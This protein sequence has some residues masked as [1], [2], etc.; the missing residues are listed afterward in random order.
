LKNGEHLCTYFSHS[1]NF[2]KSLHSH[3]ENVILAHIFLLRRIK[4]KTIVLP[5][6]NKR[7]FEKIFYTFVCI[8]ILKILKKKKKTFVHILKICKKY[9]ETK[10]CLKKHFLHICIHLVFIFSF[11]KKILKKNNDKLFHLHN[12][13][14]T[15][16]EFW[17]T[18]F[19]CIHAFSF[20]LK[21]KEKKEKKENF[22]KKNNK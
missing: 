3:F 11:G 10:N 4:K 17:N 7:T 1:K 16:R 21:K 8:L 14:H 6:P 13:I 22:S 18:K 20:F 9:F 12:R 5:I 2:G 19:L 15:Y